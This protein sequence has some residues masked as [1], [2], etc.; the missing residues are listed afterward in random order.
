MYTAPFVFVLDGSKVSRLRLVRIHLDL[1]IKELILQ[2]VQVLKRSLV[3]LAEVVCG[4]LGLHS[5]THEL[6]G[7]YVRLYASLDVGD[8]LDNGWL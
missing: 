7:V 1:H 2:A 4:L 8:S 5:S 3:S 6:L